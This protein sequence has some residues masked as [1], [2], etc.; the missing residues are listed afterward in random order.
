MDSH[1]RLL[2]LSK[3]SPIVKT[4]Q[5]IQLLRNNAHVLNQTQATQNPL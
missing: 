1:L 4:N 3:N 2:P 5:M